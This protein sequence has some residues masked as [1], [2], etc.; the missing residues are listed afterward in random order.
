MAVLANA[1]R[2]RIR[3]LD[4]RGPEYGGRERTR[5]CDQVSDWRWLASFASR[6]EGHSVRGDEG[7]VVW[8]F[9]IRL[10]NQR[11]SKPLPLA[12]LSFTLIRDPNPDAAHYMALAPPTACP[13]RP[14]M[15]P[16]RRQ[17]P[18]QVV[19]RRAMKKPRVDRS[20]RFAPSAPPS[21]LSTIRRHCRGLSADHSCSRYGFS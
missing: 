20:R 19:V 16:S 11:M 18:V 6:F 7:H 1:D 10:P 8:G 3:I 15:G 13:S 12:G 2:M 17:D 4:M 5:W 21:R 9:W 14:R